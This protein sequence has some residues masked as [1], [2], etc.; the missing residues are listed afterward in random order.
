MGLIIGL[1]AWLVGEA[2]RLA[3]HHAKRDGQGD[4]AGITY[5]GNLARGAVWLCA[6]LFYASLVPALEKFRKPDSFATAA[7]YAVVV[8]LVAWLTGGF[9]RVALHRVLEKR[10]ESVD[11]TAV[12][13]L[14]QLLRVGVWVLSAIMG[15]CGGSCA[16]R[17]SILVSGSSK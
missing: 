5:L 8:G 12:R 15:I 13:F 4:Q 6:F 3:V 14:S 11:Q 2:V 1:L 9:L 16:T 7:F 10:G 17:S